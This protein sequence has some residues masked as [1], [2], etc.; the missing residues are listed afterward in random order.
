MVLVL[1]D[2]DCHF[3]NFWVRFI[4]PRDRRKV[5]KFA[6]LTMVP[7][8]PQN[9]IMVV[10][11]GLIFQK[12]EAV[13]KIAENLGI[14]SWLTDFLRKIPRPLR[15][16][17]YDFIADRRYLISRIMNV[18]SGANC[19]IPTPMERQRFVYKPQEVRALVNF[20]SLQGNGFTAPL[21]NN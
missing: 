8:V 1:F 4:L 21:S 13:F 17:G 12:S 3:C 15:D 5:F 10:T 9:S 7:E 20:S 19:P 14:P 2:G 6:P 18:Q 11:E 16:L